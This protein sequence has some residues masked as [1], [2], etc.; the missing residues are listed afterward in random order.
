MPDESISPTKLN[1]KNV[2]ASTRFNAK[3][4]DRIIYLRDY[5]MSG[6]KKKKNNNNR[7]IHEICF[8]QGSEPELFK[9]S[10]DP[11]ETET[12]WTV[13]IAVPAALFSTDR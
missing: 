4:S 3:F 6:K 10:N 7:N 12:D 9:S 1:V 11:I 13:E 8:L 5:G 2:V